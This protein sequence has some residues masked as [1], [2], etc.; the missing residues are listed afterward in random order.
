MRDE[1]HVAAERTRH[2]DPGKYRGIQQVTSEQGLFEVCAVDH[3]A[4]FAR[5]LN[6]D[7]AAVA[8]EEIVRAKS[9]LISALAP[10]SSAVLLDAQYGLQSVAAG[11]V[12]RETGIILA[13]EEETYSAPS[14]ARPS[15]MRADWDALKAL[16]AGAGMAKL[17]WFYRPDLDQNVAQGQRELLAKVQAE[18]D[19]VSLPLVVEPIWFPVA[20]EDPQDPR[21]RASRAEGIITSAREASEIGADLLKIEFPGDVDSDDA[22]VRALDACQRVDAS[23]S[24]PWVLLSA[25]VGFADFTT[26]LEIATKSGASGYMAGR[27]VWRDAVTLDADAREAGIAVAVQKLDQLR[28]ITRR[29]ARPFRAAVS[30]EQASQ[31]MTE[32]WYARW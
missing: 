16:R 2:V 15:S 7:P 18:C 29:Y 32:G 8:M 12:P 4:D 30:I 9:E 10:H 20:G 19:A 23:I 17:L 31:A 1:V 6:P 22:I 21:W 26:Q 25:G 3:L 27:S 28:T 14:F 5:L 11:I 13:I 24:V